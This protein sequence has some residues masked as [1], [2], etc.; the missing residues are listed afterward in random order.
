MINVIT[1]NCGIAKT[2]Y[3][4]E[5]IT[6]EFLKKFLNKVEPELSVNIYEDQSC[7]WLNVEGQTWAEKQDGF[8]LFSCYEQTLNWETVQP[9]L[10]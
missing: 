1:L 5:E 4:K 7:K 9:V 3:T 2:F 8:S 6:L 10:V